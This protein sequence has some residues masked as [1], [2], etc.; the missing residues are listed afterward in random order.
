MNLVRFL[1]DDGRAKLGVLDPAGI[2]PLPLPD[3]ATLLRH[4]AAEIRELTEQA[5][6]TGAIRS[7]ART[8]LLAPIDGLTEVWGAGVTYL[9]S[10]SARM[11]ES[12]HD[13]VYQDVYD[14]QR[15]EL[16]FKSAAWR[17]RTDGE[18]AGIR[19]DCPDS[20][21]EPELCLVLNRHAEII[22]ALVG[23]DVTARGIE[24]ENPIYLPQAKLYAGSCALSARIVPWW[25]ITAPEDL[26]IKMTIQRGQET[27]F[28]GETRT[29]SMK[30]G[31]AE[32]IE[33]LFQANEFPD[34]VVLST[35]TGIV[36]PLGEGLHD[37]DVVTVCIDQVG[38]LTN[39]IA[40]IQRTEGALAR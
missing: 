30:R 29:S 10:R 23:N 34:G 40:Q 5:I 4:S 13:L 3:M 1:D 28:S 32:L 33:W 35:G 8:P 17:V 15:P 14:A 26:G 12:R 19:P 16:F 25:S 2:H 7:L 22:G 31:Y 36:P 21:P 18:Q 27:A 9:L 38:V 6:E 37:G 39:T 20:V 11:E 24:A